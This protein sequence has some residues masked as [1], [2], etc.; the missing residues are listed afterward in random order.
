MTD[1]NLNVQLVS[2]TSG[3]NAVT[4][5]QDI[6]TDTLSIN[7]ISQMISA[8]RLGISASK[9]KNNNCPVF[10]GENSITVNLDFYSW[11]EDLY[12]DYNVSISQGEL[13]NLGSIQVDKNFDTIIPAKDKLKFP[14]IIDDFSLDWITPCVSDRGQLVQIPDYTFNDNTIEFEYPIFAVIY[15]TGKAVGYKHSAI[16]TVDKDPNMRIVDLECIARAD[17]GVDKDTEIHLKVPECAQSY[18]QLCPTIFKYI[19][20]D[21]DDLPRVNIM[22]SICDGSV[23]HIDTTDPCDD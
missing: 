16:I 13:K 20:V 6:I 11:P 15:V 7:D 14:Y 17:W 8:A 2:S 22:Y 3:D 4:L 21:C 10:I 18:L 9:Y 5:E 23:L 12:M 19:N 1:S